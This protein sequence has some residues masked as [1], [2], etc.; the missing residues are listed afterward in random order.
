M[1]RLGGREMSVP[2]WGQ[3]EASDKQRVSLATAA[4]SNLAY[5]MN[6]MNDQIGGAT[7]SSVSFSGRKPATKSA[8][9]WAGLF[10][11]LLQVIGEL[12]RGSAVSKS[13]AHVLLLL[14]AIQVCTDAHGC[15]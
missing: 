7:Q 10:R 2:S 11:R 1:Q 6:S 9:W 15:R 8:M 3:V 5:S 13:T 12:Q 14:S 4:T